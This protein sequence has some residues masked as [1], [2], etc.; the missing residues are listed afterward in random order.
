MVRLPRVENQPGS[1][2]P[3]PLTVK[4]CRASDDSA[5]A[6][7]HFPEILAHAFAIASTPSACMA[8][9]S[10]RGTWVPRAAR[11]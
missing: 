1:S 3:L 2:H 10:P 6:A 9:P 7:D 5:A 11:S 8:A 4:V